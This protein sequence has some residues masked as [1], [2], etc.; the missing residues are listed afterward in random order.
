MNTPVSFRMAANN[1]NAKVIGFTSATHTNGTTYYRVDN[2]V[3]PANTNGVILAPVSTAAVNVTRGGSNIYTVKLPAGVTAD[4]NITVN[5]S[6][7]GTTSAFNTPPHQRR[8]PQRG[9]R[10]SHDNYP[11]QYQLCARRYHRLHQSGDHHGRRPD[12]GQA[13][14]PDGLPGQPDGGGNLFGYQRDGVQL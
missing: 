10:R 2:G 6:Y 14:R 4:R 7:S 9:K 13:F 8:D 12:T 1:Y 3:I 5:L 11:E